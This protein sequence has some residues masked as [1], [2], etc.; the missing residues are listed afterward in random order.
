[1]TKR[2]I[3]LL[4]TLCLVLLA[5]DE[6]SAQRYSEKSLRG[7]WAFVSDGFIGTSWAPSTGLGIADGAGG[8]VTK[9]VL[10]LGLGGADPFAV[11]PND[12]R[13]A[14]TLESVGC[15]YTVNPDGTGIWT[16]VT[17]AGEFIL[18]FV[19]VSPNEWFWIGTDSN[20][21]TTAKGISKRRTG[22]N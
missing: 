12:D 10:I 2:T 20:G 11:P 19:I 3:P 7:T 16:V 4:L 22:S 18:N 17:P 5:A 8:C 13:T 21:F 6:A 14:L 9:S 15:S 1:M